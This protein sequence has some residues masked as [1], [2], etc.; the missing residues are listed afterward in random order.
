MSLAVLSFQIAN[1][2]GFLSQLANNL[3][4]VVQQSGITLSESEENSLRAVIDGK[5][6]GIEANPSVEPW[7]IA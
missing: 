6:A 7:A 4:A 5:R 1:D 2:E 3:S